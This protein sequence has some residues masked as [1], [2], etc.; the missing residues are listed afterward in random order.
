[1]RR[2]STRLKPILRAES[3]NLKFIEH[4]EFVLEEHMTKKLQHPD[5]E[6]RRSTYKSSFK[7]AAEVKKNVQCDISGAK[8]YKGIMPG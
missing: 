6:S 3:M 1:M 4:E 7:G 5:V 8:R 2:V